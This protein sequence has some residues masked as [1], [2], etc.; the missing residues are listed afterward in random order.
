MLISYGVNEKWG[1]GGGFYWKGG[2]A[3]VTLQAQR[4]TTRPR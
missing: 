1:W 2:G 3:Q 4:P